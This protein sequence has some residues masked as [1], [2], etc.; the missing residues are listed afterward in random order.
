MTRPTS[1]PATLA[2]HPTAAQPSAARSQPAAVYLGEVQN[3]GR[4]PS[5]AAQQGFPAAQ[6]T[7]PTSG[8]ATATGMQRS[9]SQQ[10]Q[11][12][13]GAQAAMVQHMG[14]GMQGGIAHSMGVYG[15]AGNTANSSVGYA[16][17]QQAHMQQSMHAAMQAHVIQGQ[18][19]AQ[20][21]QV[22]LQQQAMLATYGGGWGGQATPMPSET[23]PSSG[24]TAASRAHVGLASGTAAGAGQ[25][26]AGALPS[27]MMPTPSGMIPTPPGMIPTPSG[28]IPTQQ[29]TAAISSAL[30][31][32][33]STRSSTLYQGE[34]RSTL[35]LSLSLRNLHQT[36]CYRRE[37]GEGWQ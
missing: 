6:P 8:Q 2:P 33:V 28:M 25:L 5:S 10:L 30:Q 7:Q 14:G 34:S 15:M 32:S 20:M 12:G 23:L 11:Q 18:M 36:S 1:A 21:Q 9:G 35:P 13:V 19:Q 26:A 22:H 29:S 37:T 4:Q 16:Q 24:H 17:M 31:P 3:G 27:G